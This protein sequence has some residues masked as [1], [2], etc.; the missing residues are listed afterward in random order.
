VDGF[1]FVVVR[2]VAVLFVVVF[3]GDADAGMATIVTVREKVNSRDS[4]ATVAAVRP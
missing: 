3:D 4:T 2:F 1:A